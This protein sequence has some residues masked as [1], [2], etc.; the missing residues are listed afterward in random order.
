MQSSDNDGAMNL[1]KLYEYNKSDPHRNGFCHNSRVFG[2]VFGAMY[3]R[4]EHF[5]DVVAL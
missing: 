5:V 1:Y 2:N 3:I 4:R